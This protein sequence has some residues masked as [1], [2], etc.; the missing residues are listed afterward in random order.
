MY[1]FKGGLAPPLEIWLCTLMLK[2]LPDK[3]T[4]SW[5][6]LETDCKQALLSS[7]QTVP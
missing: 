6:L 5:I 2:I 7:V 3:A 1:G 4:T